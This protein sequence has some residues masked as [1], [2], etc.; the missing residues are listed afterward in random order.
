MWD[1]RYTLLALGAAAAL[2]CGDSGQTGSA[3]CVGDTPACA[4]WLLGGFRASVVMATVSQ[5]NE[6]E[7][8]VV[9]DVDGVEWAS[10]ARGL[11]VPP[12]TIENAAP[13]WHVSGKYQ[14]IDLARAGDHAS[15]GA[16][17]APAVGERVRA[18]FGLS[19]AG[20]NCAGCVRDMDCDLYC[21]P[22]GAAAT[23][24]V[25]DG[26]WLL[27]LADSY[28]FGGTVL[29]GAEVTAMDPQDCAALFPPRPA[30]TCNDTIEGNEGWGC[31]VSPPARG[32]GSS[33]RWCAVAMA[34][35]ALRRRR[36]RR[37]VTAPTGSRPSRF[38]CTGTS[39]GRP[40]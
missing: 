14:Q 27:P 29:S 22:L 21:P 8:S 7:G 30:P 33:L 19:M 25:Y 11:V 18:G 28:D 40:R 2:G 38:P 5:V 23:L 35:G 31:A 12:V 6:A 1:L 36:Q 3:D 34:V 16:P 9:L 17:P 32:D 20:F 24:H 15:C 13:G 37:A 10:T 39:T 26:I 4:C